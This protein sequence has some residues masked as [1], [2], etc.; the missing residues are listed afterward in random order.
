MDRHG[1]I[2][3]LAALVL[4][5][6]VLL[7][8][9]VWGKLQRRRRLLAAELPTEWQ[10]VLETI[11]L[12]RRMPGELRKPLHGILQV[13]MAEKRFEGCGGQVITDEIRVTILGQAA[14]L[15]LS[16]KTRYFRRLK[17][18][19]V[20]P[21]SFAAESSEFDG[22]VVTE[23]V[24]EHLGESWQN[25]PV[26]LAWEDVLEDVN[27]VRRGDNVVLHEFAHQLDQEDGEADGAP[28]LESASGYPRWAQ[29]FGEEF[30]KLKSGKERSVISEYGAEDP[31]E[32]FATA[33]EAFFE[34][35]RALRDRHP[36]LYQEL[37]GYYKVDPAQWEEQ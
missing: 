34:K 4:W 35:S 20:Y 9:P 19:Y 22:V 6:F 18:I 30:E 32:F 33:T 8:L 23:E 12:Y 25:G 26:V 24:S 15:L 3:T 28:P 17:T 7:C 2:F 13:L 11:P 27:G 10:A 14:M 16:R 29:V 31:A 36:N 21:T 1:I 37:K 5:L